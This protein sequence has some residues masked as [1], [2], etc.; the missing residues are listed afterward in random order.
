MSLADLP[1]VNHVMDNRQL[2]NTLAMIVKELEFVLN[3]HLDAKNIRA[4]SIESKN[5][6][7][8]AV[9][10]EKIDVNELSA[11]SANLGTITAGL[12]QAV[13]ILA[14][15]ITGSTVQT[16]PP[17]VYP[18]IELNSIGNLLAAYRNA[19]QYIGIAPNLT[20]SPALAFWENGSTPDGSLSWVV[21]TLYLK[22]FQK[23]FLD[24]AEVKVPSWAQ[25]KN[26]ANGQTLQA[27]LNYLQAQ[28]NN[29]QA[30]ISSK[31]NAGINATI[32]VVTSIVGGT[33]TYA[34]LHFTNGVLTSV[35]T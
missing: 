29:L 16:S 35:T 26:D 33:P 15:T 32:S 19:L 31:P 27:D 21:D 23:M 34:L 14:S 8:G 25:F 18:R 4:E 28:I 22:S 12:L 6:K 20:G 13:T 3:G 9:T 10:A 30:Q 17:G 2:S 5:L 24:G 11:I 7:A 1:R